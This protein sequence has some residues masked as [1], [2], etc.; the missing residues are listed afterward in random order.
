MREKP[1]TFKSKKRTPSGKGGNLKGS[2]SVWVSIRYL[3]A[4]GI[5][6]KIGTFLFTHVNMGNGEKCLF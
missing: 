6:Q 5:C 2:G 3:I 4:G 1:E